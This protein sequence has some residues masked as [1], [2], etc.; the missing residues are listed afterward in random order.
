MLLC[1]NLDKIKGPKEHIS[2]IKLQK[3]KK[4]LGEK[5]PWN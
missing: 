3:K 1:Y 4:R 2:Q 5:M